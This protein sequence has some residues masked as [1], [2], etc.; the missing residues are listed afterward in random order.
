MAENRQ[1]ILFIDL[2]LELPEGIIQEAPPVRTSNGEVYW[3]L[4]LEKAGD[5]TVTVQTGQEAYDKILSVGGDLRKVSWL[6]TNGW[7][8][9]LYPGEIP[10]SSTS[11]ITTIEFA[12]PETE[13]GWLPGGELGIVLWFLGLSLVIGYVFK[14]RFGVSL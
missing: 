5:H 2:S 4:R 8:A 7:L 14:D 11:P 13:L 12:M 6:R 10:F 3:R 9:L 1:G